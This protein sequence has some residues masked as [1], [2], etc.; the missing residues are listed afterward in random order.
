MTGAGISPV[1]IV[2]SFVTVLLHLKNV[3][4]ELNLW[5]YNTFVKEVNY[6]NASTHLLNFLRRKMK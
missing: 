2:D 1:V 6:A 5:C 4:D 3:I